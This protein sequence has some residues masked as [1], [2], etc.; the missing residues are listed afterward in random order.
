MKRK[1]EEEVA[2]IDPFVSYSLW[3]LPWLARV[4]ENLLQTLYSRG[5]PVQRWHLWKQ[6]S[7]PKPRSKA[8]T[9]FP[10]SEI[11]V[12]GFGFLHSI[13]PD[14][15]K[16]PVC[17]CRIPSWVQGE[18]RRRHLQTSVQC[19]AELTI[20]IA[21][22]QCS[23]QQRKRSRAGEAVRKSPRKPL[24]TCIIFKLCPVKLWFH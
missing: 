9:F 14:L 10:A 15:L 18:S 3:H 8:L 16:V 24:V 6:A 12:F 2:F 23:Q 13:A 1:E 22:Q 17:K 20:S 5:G 4:C 7:H 19:F 11:F 21:R